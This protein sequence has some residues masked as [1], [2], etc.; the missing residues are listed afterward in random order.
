MIQ[1]LYGQFESVKLKNG[2]TIYALQMAVPW[3]RMSFMVHSGGV[4][5]PA[6]KEGTAHFVEHLISH[7]ALI[8]CDALEDYFNEKGGGVMLGA[9]GYWYT[10]YRF[11][12]PAEDA[13][14]T[15]SLEYFSNMLLHEVLEQRIELE[16]NVIV[17]EYNKKYPLASKYELMMHTHQT[18][19]GGMLVGRCLDRLGT[20]ATIAAITQ[21]DLQ[22]FY[23]T[24]Y[25]PQNMS[26]V[27]VGAYS[28]EQL[29]EFFSKSHFGDHKTGDRTVFEPTIAFP[30]LAM[31]RKDVCI[32]DYMGLNNPAVNGAYESHLRLPIILKQ[33][34]L[35]IFCRMVK[36]ELDT[37]VRQE[38]GWTYAINASYG[39]YIQFYHL[40]IEC[41]SLAVAGLECIE[42]IVNTVILTLGEKEDLFNKAKQNK[43]ANAIMNDENGLGILKEAS[44]N[45]LCHGDIISIASYV[46]AIEQ[47]QFSDVLAVGSYWKPEN[48]FTVLTRP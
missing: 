33:N 28:L 8:P 42:E 25:T 17:N 30:P 10:E 41:A 1:D 3:Q 47:V 2:L 18:L 15:R 38:K 48:I 22:E 24:H 5:D 46:A 27:G 32:S 11:F 29:V 43:L 21:A 44:S 20:P 7:N 39:H 45:I 19:F 12:I 26:I 34:A 14:L 31:N 40:H 9:T 6:G 16:R 23:D 35:E 37:I 4:Q 36:D 13:V